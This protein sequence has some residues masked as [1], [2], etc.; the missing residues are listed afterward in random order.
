MIIGRLNDGEKRFG[1][2]GQHFIR[3]QEKILIADAPYINFRRIKI[4]LFI[5][6]QT[7]NIIRK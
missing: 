3:F 5:Q 4:V 6:F 2:F 1:F 7:R